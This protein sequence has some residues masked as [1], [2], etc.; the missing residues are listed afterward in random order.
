MTKME[1]PSGLKRIVY[2]Y[3]NQKM[4]FDEQT[5]SNSTRQGGIYMCGITTDL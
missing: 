2:K 5:D 4:I 1:W 3:F